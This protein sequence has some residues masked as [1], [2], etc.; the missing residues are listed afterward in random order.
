MYA[1]KAYEGIQ[2]K[3]YETHDRSPSS[4]ER[5]RLENFLSDHPNES[6]FYGNS[7]VF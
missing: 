7:N 2:T 1:N 6:C 5:K 3:P 4:T